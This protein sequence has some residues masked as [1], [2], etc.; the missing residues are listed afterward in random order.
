MKRELIA[1]ACHAI[2][3]AY[4]LSHGDTSHKPWD[5]CSDEL[6]ASI[7]AGVDLHLNDPAAT[8]EQSHEAWL[9]G[10]TA[11]GWKYGKNKDAKKKTHPCFLPY[12]E[13]PAEQKAKDYLFRAVVHQLKDLPDEAAP[14]DVE[15]Q[16]AERAK[17]RAE[18]L[19]E[20]REEF[21]RE[22]AEFV[23]QAK[24]GGA[25]TAAATVKGAQVPVRYIGHRPTYKEGAYGTG[26]IFT[27][28]KSEFVPAK[29]AALLLKHTDVYQPGDASEC[30]QVVVDRK[31]TDD[32]DD[33]AQVARDAIAVS[34]KEALTA[35][36][37]V[38]FGVELDP[39]DTVEQQR[40][41]V[42]GLIDQYGIA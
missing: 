12:A 6:K 33:P 36:A 30:G 26:I 17:M 9:A 13:L 16:A 14:L 19:T 3:T 31:T 40:V 37:R 20:L 23:R 28:G 25:S 42:T 35:Y 29:E 1:A 4:C 41:R 39:Q 32:S 27:K 10:K 2:N 8:P 24:A 18:L 34:G 7:L 11:E 22:A 15:T 38:H 21:H 5:E